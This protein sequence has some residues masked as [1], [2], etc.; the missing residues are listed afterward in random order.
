MGAVIIRCIVILS[1]TKNSDFPVVNFYRNAISVFN[2]I[3]NR[4]NV[5]SSGHLIIF[6]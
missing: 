1:A 3:T 2:I 4:Y 6:I 5:P